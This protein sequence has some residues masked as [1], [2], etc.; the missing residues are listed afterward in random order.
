MIAAFGILQLALMRLIPG[1]RI[2]GPLTV[3]GNLPIYKD[4]GFLCF[5]ITLA[6]F[7]ICSKVF[8]L[9]P[10]AIIYDNFAAMIGALNIFSLGFCL[11]LYLKGRFF[12]S[13]SDSGCSGNC[14]FD[15]YWG[16]ELY[17]RIMNWDLKQFTNCRFGMMSWPLIILSF[18]AKQTELYGL[19]D[20]MVVALIVMMTYITK[21]F[22]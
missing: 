10:L 6:I 13:S 11:F 1:K 7:I 17:P 4:N 22:I 12:P 18:A 8:H 19:S 5:L 21:F 3:K 2:K 15:Y 14:I 16:T 9:F 20:S